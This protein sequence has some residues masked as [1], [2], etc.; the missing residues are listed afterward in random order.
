MY[1]RILKR[2]MFKRGGSSYQSQGTGI[3]SPYDTP[4]KRYAEGPSWEEINERRSNI[5]QP[6]SEMD[7][8][9][10]GFSALGDPYKKSG[11]AKTIGE[12]L[13]EGAGQVRKSRAADKALGQS[14]DLANIESDASR[15]LADEKHARDLELVEAQA[16]S[17]LNK[18]YSIKR[19]V[20]D[21]TKQLN[22]Q[23][24]NQAYEGAE[25]INDGFAQSIAQGT[26][27]INENGYHAMVVPMSAI[28][29]TE[30]VWRINKDILAPGMV[31]W[32]PIN[33]QWLIVQNARTKN[34][35][36]IHYGSYAE[37]KAG[38]KVTNTE[39]GSSTSGADSTSSDAS[40]TEIKNN[41]IKMKIVTNLKDVDIN[42]K[43]V[44]YDEAQKVGIKIVENTEGSK[45]F[46]KN[47]ADNEM[48][49]F[50]F[51]E[52]LKKKKMSDTY[53]H[54]SSK[55]GKRGDVFDQITEEIK[56]AE[57]ATGGRAGYASGTEPDDDLNELTSWWKSEVDNSFNS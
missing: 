26:V 19:Q 28:K 37:A 5:F 29:R 41:E 1:N 10:E 4:R 23:A 46:I 3:T 57:M 16:K 49:L 15:L 52:I 11:D 21:L 20:L 50:T 55:K 33:Q 34:A 9:A 22:K 38:L 14:V 43:S 2:P 24:E 47:L 36:P 18:D 7:F 45:Q 31:Y 12:M 54:I 53:G 17:T 30:G 32:N 27:E 51:T 13:Y 40:D 39:E 48:T 42:D 44:I 56:V 35:T 6:R 25:F 8:A